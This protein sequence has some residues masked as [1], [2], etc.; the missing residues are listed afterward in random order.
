MYD[1]LVDEFMREMRMQKPS[2]LVQFEDFGTRT[3]RVLQITGACNRVLTTTVGTACDVAALEAALRE[4]KKALKDITVLFYVGNR[5]GI[6]ELVMR[7]LE[8]SGGLSHEEAKR[9]VFSWT[10][11][12]W[13]L[14]QVT[15]VTAAQNSVRTRVRTGKRFENGD[16]ETQTDGPDWRFYDTQ[17]V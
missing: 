12:D 1:K 8:K 11:K 9:G 5:V 7:A 3:F 15:R 2:C 16:C 10:R 14:I 17:R 6:G 4:Q 13:W